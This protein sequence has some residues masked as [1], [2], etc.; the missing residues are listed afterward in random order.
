MCSS[1]Y[2]LLLLCTTQLAV[3]VPLN[4][5]VGPNVSFAMETGNYF[6]TFYPS[7]TFCAQVCDSSARCNSFS[8]GDRGDAG[9]V[10]SDG[11]GNNYRFGHCILSSDSAS[12]G[13][14]AEYVDFDFYEETDAGPTPDPSNSAAISG[15][16]GPFNGTSTGGVDDITGRGGIEVESAVACAELCDSHTECRSFDYGARGPAERSCHLSRVDREQA[17]PAF[18]VW[19][20]YD[21]YERIMQSITE[22]LGDNGTFSILAGAIAQTELRA[23]LSGP[24]PFTVFAPSD[25][26]FQRAGIASSAD[27][28]N[29]PN[30]LRLLEYHV[31]YG[32]FE[33]LTLEDEDKLLTAHGE[34]VSVSVSAA[35]DGGRV[36]EVGTAPLVSANLEC[37]NGVIHTMDGV[38]Q[39]PLAREPETIMEM[40]RSRGFTTL[41]Q[42]MV[43]S[44][45][46][47]EMAEQGEDWTLFAPSDTALTA[48]RLSEGLGEGAFLASED[49]RNLL[50]R[51]IVA[52]RVETNQADGDGVRLRLVSKAESTLTLRRSPSKSY[53][54]Q[55]GDAVAAV[56][57]FDL[58]ATDGVLHAIDRVLAEPDRPRGGGGPRIV[59]VTVPAE[60]DDDG[61]G[62]RPAV[63]VLIVMVV[64]AVVLCP[65]C[66]YIGY[67]SRSNR[68]SAVLEAA[69][70]QDGVTVVMGKP[71]GPDTTAAAQGPKGDLENGVE[72]GKPVAVVPGQLMLG[73]NNAQSGSASSSAPN[74]PAAVYARAPTR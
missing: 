36:V 26:V 28:L 39:L 66:F 72:A 59:Y 49:L 12:T 47:A 69:V 51:H 61:K 31:V 54:V 46:A 5:F 35:A 50:L 40:L 13:T 29:Q 9:L 18:T 30:A 10:V 63:V 23:V 14:L 73:G 20:L 3:A 48:F 70:Q 55:S 27:L 58:E 19:P 4:G 42:A 53:F 33:A 2:F 7:L 60:S 15:Y 24:G 22:V 62:V 65:I 74:P 37:S 64:L 25:A 56:G 41:R 57:P 68:K 38:L 6:E 8:W 45:V 34:Q 67:K 71:V 52:G 32:R 43:A 1:F 17:G 44:G 11:Q 16:I 21:Y